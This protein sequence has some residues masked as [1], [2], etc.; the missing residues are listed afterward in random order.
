MKALTEQHLSASRA[1]PRKAPPL[2]LGD[3]TDKQ[4]R[5]RA[6]RERKLIARFYRA[7]RQ[8]P[9]EGDAKLCHRHRVVASASEA[10]LRLK[11]MEST[12]AKHVAPAWR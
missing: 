7:L 9:A 8:R 10:R 4:L 12:T 5:Q 11:H 2:W 6:K 3:K 1:M